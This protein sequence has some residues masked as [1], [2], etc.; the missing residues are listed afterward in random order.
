MD[1]ATSTTLTGALPGGFWFLGELLFRWVPAVVSVVVSGASN[2]AS[3][4][5]NFAEPVS[6]W[7]VPSLLEQTSSAAA[8]GGFVQGWYLF[9]LI[10]LTASIPFLALV[11]YCWI[12]IIQIRR[13]E[14]R[15]V[16]AVRRTVASQDIPRTQLR[17]NRVLEQA[18]ATNPESW[19]L[20]ILEADI[21]LNEL[22]DMQGYKGE[23]IADKMKQVDRNKFNSIESAWDAHKI[24]NRIAHE[25]GLTL[26]PREVRNAITL[27]ERVFREFRYLE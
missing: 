22:L 23:T 8:Y 18:N 7:N 4:Y 27:Y 26:T 10:T 5:A 11:L 16:E 21:I 19:R 13:A 3:P 9:T 12:R 17:W 1:A 25:G 20:A 14:R 2:Q 15:A 6:L 24:R